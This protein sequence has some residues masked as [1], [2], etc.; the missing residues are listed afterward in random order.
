M[1]RELLEYR[2][3][4]KEPVGVTDR[5]EIACLMRGEMANVMPPDYKGVDKGDEV[6]LYAAPKLQPVSNPYTLPDEM[7]PEMMRAVQLNSELGAYATS[8]LTG[9]YTLFGEFWRVAYRAA[10]AQSSRASEKCHK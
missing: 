9:A 8:N 10:K 5:S 4:S 6:F 2:K 7:T 3:A 1:A